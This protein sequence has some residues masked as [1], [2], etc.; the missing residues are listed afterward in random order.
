M[1]ELVVQLVEAARADQLALLDYQTEP[2]CWRRYFGPHGNREVLKPDL[3]LTVGTVSLEHHWFV[4][5]D[6]SSEH[7]PAVVRKCR[8]YAAYYQSGQEQ[9]RVGIF[10][11]VAWLCTTTERANRLAAAIAA[12]VNLTH[13]LFAV[14]PM[15]TALD[16][17]SGRE[18]R[19]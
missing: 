15:A 16:L 6:L 11:R 3:R 2:T 4:E 7:L 5:V 14:Q 13:E 9:H 17:L 8:Q 18:S 1:A 12:D 19:A 10:P